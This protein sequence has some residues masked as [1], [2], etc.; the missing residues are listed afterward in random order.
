MG[1][2]R[3]M[4]SHYAHYRFGAEQLKAMP[5]DIR[6]SVQ[7]FRQLYDA[8]LHGPDFFF[9]FSPFRTTGTGKLGRTFHAQSGRDFFTR[10]CRGLRMQP[11][12]EGLAYLYGV[13]AHYC[14]DSVC[15]PYVRETAAAGE[16]GHAEIETEFDRYLLE[17]DGKLLPKPA[18]P[19]AHMRLS[20]A[21]CQV[22]AAFY[23]GCEA[24]DVRTGM[25]NMAFFVK[26]LTGP[27]S[28]GQRVVKQGAALLGDY[29]QHVLTPE[30][31]TRCRETNAQLESLY[32]KASR[33]YPIL[34]T[35]LQAHL[36][37]G[38]PPGPE[39]GA[40]FG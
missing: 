16:L 22:I 25:K 33:L 35:R 15:H 39:F 6:Q 40:N 28:L 14:L 3:S 11:S 29:G 7:R 30:P 20:Q 31:N 8:G 2:N 34:M 12:E 17:Q 27:N 24:A 4:P 26:L 37:Y 21:Q 13:L 36:S 38:A 5:A 32:G 10:V 18:I 1:V 9:Y 23:P 19:T